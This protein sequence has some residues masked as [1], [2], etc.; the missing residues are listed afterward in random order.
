MGTVTVSNVYVVWLALKDAEPM[1]VYLYLRGTSAK[2]AAQNSDGTAY[3]GVKR[4]LYEPNLNTVRVRGTV[5]DPR[6]TFRDTL[7][8]VPALEAFHVW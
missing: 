4:S 8:I 3:S 1:V 7:L 5:W 6:A 2:M